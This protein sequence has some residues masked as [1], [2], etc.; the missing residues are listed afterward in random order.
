MSQRRQL[1]RRPHGPCDET[2]FVSR[3]VFIGQL[4]GQFRGPLVQGVGVLFEAVLRQ[5]YRCCTKGVRFDH[6]AASIEEL[7]MHRLHCI[8]LGDHQIFVATLQGFS[9]KIIGTEV[10]LLQG[11]ARSSVE[12]QHRSTWVVK[13]RQE[14]GGLGDGV[15]LDCLHHHALDPTIL[16]T[17]GAQA[18]GLRPS[19]MV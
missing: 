3:A 1:G 18:R 8:R 9:T 14:A 17:V 11:G 13:S 4:P 16:G 19:W 10:Q 12:H 2:R 15:V 5:H 6:I 7:S